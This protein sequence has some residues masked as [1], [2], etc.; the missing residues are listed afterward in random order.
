MHRQLSMFEIITARMVQV[1]EGETGWLRLESNNGYDNKARAKAVAFGK[2]E[3]RERTLVGGGR[4]ERDAVREKYCCHHVVPPAMIGC[5]SQ[6]A[7]PR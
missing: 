5:E 3:L 1:G 2:A 6:P 7:D 4:Q